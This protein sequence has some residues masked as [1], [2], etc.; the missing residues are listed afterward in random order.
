MPWRISFDEKT[1]QL[2]C[3]DVGQD[4]YEEVNIIEKGRNYGW[5]A[6]EG[7][8]TYDTTLYASSDFVLPVIEYKHPEGVSITGGYVYR[9]KQFPAMEGK[10]IFGDWAFK[11]F[12]LDHENG[13]W[14]KHDCHFA[15]RDNNTFNFRINSFGVDEQGEIYVVTQDEVGAISPTGI[16]YKIGLADRHPSH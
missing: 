4:L 5:R 14:I 10:Y 12:Y 11:L 16:I 2:F 8:H 7:F 6:M 9:G 15:G 1:G 13:K 3:G